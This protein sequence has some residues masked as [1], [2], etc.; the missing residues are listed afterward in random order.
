MEP[1]LMSDMPDKILC[2]PVEIHVTH[3]CNLSCHGCNHYSNYQ[4]PKWFIS[5]Q[6]FEAWVQAWSSKIV[7][8][9]FNLLGGEPTLHPKLVELLS[10]A[11]KYFQR[12]RFDEMG[13]DSP[14]CLIT[15]GTALHRHAGLKEL[16]IKHR[17]RLF[18][19]VHYNK[20][21]E[22]IELVESWGK[23]G[24]PVTIFDYAINKDWRKFYKGHGSEME[25]FSD[26]N[27]R[28]SWEKCNAKN[29][30]QLFDGKMWKCANIAYL[31]LAKRALN[32][33][34]KWDEYLAYQPLSPDES[35]SAITQ[36]FKREEESICSMC[37]SNPE[38]I[39]NTCDA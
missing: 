32:I 16:M 15:N 31:I 23:D 29:Y 37:P 25:P 2:P 34:K 14:I 12:G 35:K 21:A 8:S 7:P 38:M 28:Q 33:S 5:T 11:T 3:N 19:S 26:E 36:F 17:I 24:V 18:L 10:I 13:R 39:E 27:P 1:T 30:F 4:L 6:E 22:V 20:P 9:T